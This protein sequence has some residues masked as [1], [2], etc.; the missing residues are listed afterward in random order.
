MKRRDVPGFR[1]LV[2]DAPETPYI[3]DL[4]DEL[5]AAREKTN[6]LREELLSTY[7]LY[8]AHARKH[9]ALEQKVADERI[10]EYQRA[11]AVPPSVSPPPLALSTGDSDPFRLAAPAEDMP[12]ASH[13]MMST[14][15]RSRFEPR[16]DDGVIIDFRRGA[17]PA[18]PPATTTDEL[19]PLDASTGHDGAIFLTSN[20]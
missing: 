3:F 4:P 16:P 1:I 10:Q 9:A 6:T 2:P 13:A 18:P 17:A 12:D 7:S 15:V 19:D 8:C 11:R 14:F 20:D 5:K